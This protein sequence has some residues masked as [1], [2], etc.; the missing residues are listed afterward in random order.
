MN[1]A[2]ADGLLDTDSQGGSGSGGFGSDKQSVVPATRL[3]PKPTMVSAIRRFPPGC[4]RVTGLQPLN[5]SADKSPLKESKELSAAGGSSG[6]KK[7]KLIV[8]C[9][10]HPGMKIASACTMGTINKPDDVAASILQDDGFLKSLAD[11]ERKLELKLSVSSD[12]P[13]VRC[14]RQHGTQN[15]DDRSKV[16]MMCKRFHFIC[17]AVVQF[18]EQRSLKSSRIDITA[19]KVIRKLPGFTQHGPII[20]NIPGVEIGDEFVYRVEL[21][22]VGLHRPYQGGIDITR[23]GNDVPV[24]ISIVASGGYPDELS[25]SGELVYTGSGGKLAGKK[26][27]ENQKLER[28]NLGLKNCIQTMTPVRVIHGF[29]SREEASHSRVKRALSFTYDGLYHVV[30][31]WREGQAGSKVFKYKLQRIPGQPQLPYCSKT[32]RSSKTGIIC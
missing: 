29:K 11:Y 17:K 4:G 23:V 16:K 5:K 1:V 32:S 26:G 25:S 13:S 30:D 28:G 21:A 15:A 20:G 6:L 3:L 22:L 31:F 18:V 2:A 7:K 9:P 10:P 12:L 19:D 24:A 27:D 14:Q 8:K